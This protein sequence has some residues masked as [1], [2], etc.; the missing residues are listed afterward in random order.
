MPVWPT[1]LVRPRA[2]RRALLRLD[3]RRLDDRP[4]LLDFGLVEG[5]ERLRRPLPGREN[6]LPE[7]GK[8]RTH[9]GIRQRFADGGI[10]PG[11]DVLACPRP[12]YSCSAAPG[13][14]ARK[15]ARSRSS[16]CQRIVCATAR[17][18]A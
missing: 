3:V 9:R 8:P 10:E 13:C 4:P 5:A 18:T 11:D 7:I 6:L 16:V 14:A 1:S 17:Q 2:G 15:A 12:A